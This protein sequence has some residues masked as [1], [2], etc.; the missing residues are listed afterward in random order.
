M[1]VKLTTEQAQTVKPKSGTYTAEQYKAPI[2]L[3]LSEKANYGRIER[4]FPNVKP[5]HVEFKLRGLMT[6]EQAK[7]LRVGKTKDLGVCLVYSA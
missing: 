3:A 2:V 4:D 7:H 5:A 6:P 1:S